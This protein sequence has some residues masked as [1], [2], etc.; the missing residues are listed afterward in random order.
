MQYFIQST[1]PVRL[2]NVRKASTLADTSRDAQLRYGTVSAP[3]TVPVFGTVPYSRGVR[4]GFWP[5]RMTHAVNENFP[6]MRIFIRLRVSKR[7]AKRNS[8]TVVR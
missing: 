2:N 8:E 3:G 5:A 4:A 1:V 6:D 7:Y